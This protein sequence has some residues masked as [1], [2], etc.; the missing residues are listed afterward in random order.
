MNNNDTEVLQAI[1]DLDGNCLKS[2]RCI[3]CPFKHV[4]LPKFLEKRLSHQQRVNMALSHIVNTS[5]LDDD[6]YDQR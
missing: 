4:C 6:I 1:I 3:K 5:L 2:I